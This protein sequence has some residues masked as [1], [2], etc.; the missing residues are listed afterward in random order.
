M[1]MFAMRCSITGVCIVKMVIFLCFTNKK[2]VSVFSYYALEVCGNRFFVPIPSDFN[3]FIPIP[4]PF[5]FP[6]ET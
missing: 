1:W 3:E 6:S 4:T 5:P 2:Q